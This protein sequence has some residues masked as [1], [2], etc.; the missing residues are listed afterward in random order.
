MDKYE[1]NKNKRMEEIKRLKRLL[2]GQQRSLRAARQSYA[3]ELY[4]RTELQRF[5]KQCLIDVREQ[6][7]QKEQGSQ[8]ASVL[9]G[10]TMGMLVRGPLALPLFSTPQRPSP[11]SCPLHSLL[12][13]LTPQ[14]AQQQVE[15]KP[16]ELLK[17]QDRV[18]SLLY[19]KTFPTAQQSS[20]ITEEVRRIWRAMHA[21]L[22]L[23]CAPSFFS[24]PCQAFGSTTDRLTRS[25]PLVS[26]AQDLDNITEDDISSFRQEIADRPG[27]TNDVPDGAAAEIDA[28]QP[29]RP[30]TRA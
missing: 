10:K 12:S 15:E 26:H 18:I 30:T 7:T 11:D 24:C 9:S 29:H 22:S 5:L 2:E 4:G 16:L 13:Y 21:F 28:K 19:H 14:M 27:T 3:A 25:C 17:S 1:D 23:F 8:L 6:I 20:I